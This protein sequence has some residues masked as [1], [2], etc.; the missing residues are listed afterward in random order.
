MPQ[1]IKNTGLKQTEQNIIKRERTLN[2]YYN[3]GKFNDSSRIGYMMSMIRN[4]RPLTADEWK[5]WYLSN[6]HD[7]QY[8]ENLASEMFRTIPSWE[9]IGYQ[10][11]LDYIND[12][13]FRRTFLGYKKEHS[14]LAV[15]KEHVSPD[16]REAPSYWDN[17]YFIDFYLRD[18]AGNYIG[19]QLKPESFFLGHYE[20]KVDIESKMRSF[21]QRYGAKTFI[22][23]Y[24]KTK[25]KAIEFLNPSIIKEIKAALMPVHGI[26]D[27]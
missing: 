8:I 11:C 9:N 19:I 15:L 23:I 22:L 18:F 6:V 16:I 4:V 2:D 14:A 3:R 25:E 10:D 5:N 20:K 27:W 13:M 7:E 1:N 26:K 24:R 12:M 17:H 21:R